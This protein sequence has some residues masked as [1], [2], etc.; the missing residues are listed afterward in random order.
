STFR[1]DGSSKFAP[2]NQWGFFPSAAI[3]WRLSD[4]SFMSGTKSFLDD[5]KVRLSLGSAGNNRIADNAWRKTLSV[6]TGKLFIE[7]SEASPTPFLRPNGVLA[8]PLLRWETT[9]TRN[10]G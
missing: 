9:V 7:G 10:L 1:A 5:M 3:A 6:Q 2:G 4:E 8:N